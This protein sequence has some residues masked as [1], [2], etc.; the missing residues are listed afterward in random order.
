M[1][2]TVDEVQDIRFVVQSTAVLKYLQRYR[3]WMLDPLALYCCR[4][5]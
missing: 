5:L 2:E 1:T 3:C 4:R